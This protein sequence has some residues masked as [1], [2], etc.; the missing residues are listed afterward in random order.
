MLGLNLTLPRANSG[1]FPVGSRRV[2]TPGVTPDEGDYVGRLRTLFPAYTFAEFAPRHHALWRWGWSI[3]SGERPR[4]FVAIWPRGGAKSTTAEMLAVILGGRQARRYCWYISATQDQADKHVQAIADMLESDTVEYMFPGLGRRRVGKYGNS[5]GWRRERLS[6]ACGFTVDALG[7]D[8]RLRGGRDRAQRPDLM[9]LDDIDDKLDTPATTKKKIAKLTTNVLPAGSHDL[10]VLAIQNLVISN[11]VFARL[12]KPASENDAAD[13]LLD[14]IVSGPYPAI[15]GL[16]YATKPEGGYRITDGAPTWA[17]QDLEVCQSFIDTWGLTAF[18]EESQHEVD[19]PDGG[20]FSHLIYRYCAWS[21]LPDLTDIQVWVDPAVTSTDQSDSMGIQADGIAAD[22]P[23]T[24]YRLFSWEA[25]TTPEDALRRAILKAV[26][27]RASVV[28]VE[29]DQGGDTWQ[30]VFARAWRTLGEE[31]ELAKGAR[32]PT[33]R[34]AKAG[35]GHGPKA[36][37]AA[38]MLAKYE[39]GRFVHVIGTHVTLEKAL[40]RFPVAKPFDLVDAAFWASYH[41]DQRGWARGAAN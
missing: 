40:R 2:A 18:L 3:V 41:I 26:E 37:R 24:I 36:H 23:K 27:L 8:T 15:E 28:G 10:A 16:T 35:Q 32:Q 19:T 6:T 20:M 30:S 12:A 13:F 25:V 31:G 38:Q 5:Q 1:L 34:Q 22:G 33:F 4:P 7:L 29:T 9:I 17:G 14:R 21:D 39:Q 11:G